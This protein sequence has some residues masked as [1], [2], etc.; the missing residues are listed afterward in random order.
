MVDFPEMV[1]Y[2]KELRVQ[3]QAIPVPVPYPPHLYCYDG[4]TVVCQVASAL[5]DP[6]SIAAMLSAI[7]V[8]HADYAILSMESTVRSA[9]AK[10]VTLPVGQDPTSLPAMMTVA[11][12]RNGQ[13]VSVDAFQV[14]D[15]GGITWVPGLWWSPLP[16][17]LVGAMHEVFT[18]EV[19]NS[20]MDF[21]I[22][23]QLNRFG[24]KV[25][26]SLYEHPDDD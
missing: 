3:H 26:P 24:I 9:D 10:E 13:E 14:S 2:F 6:H 11:A 1:Q 7:A 12:Q 23:M 17:L 20:V 22:W 5:P 15:E 18:A 8:C 4:E 16:S 21:V 19:P 25:H